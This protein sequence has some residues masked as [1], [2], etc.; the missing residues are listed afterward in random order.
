[1]GGSPEQDIPQLESLLRQLELEYDKFL[2]GQERQEPWKTENKVLGIVRAYASR[3]IQNSTL[4]FKYNALVARYNSFKTIWSRRQREREEGRGPQAR[5][6]RAPGAPRPA[7]PPGR[8]RANTGE[9]LA[10]E[11][12][13]EQRHLTQ[14]YE[15][16]RR[17][18]EQAGESV[19]KLTPASFEKALADKIEQIKREQ[20]CEAVLVRVV[21]E[22]G[23]TRIVAKPFRRGTGKDDAAP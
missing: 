16:Y 5:A 2:C 22:N 12:R 15:T 4:S 17:L 14:F 7:A 8:G 18:R 3:P 23:R 1:M 10:S 9:Y 6:T 13:H 19:A 11:P 20:R 21:S